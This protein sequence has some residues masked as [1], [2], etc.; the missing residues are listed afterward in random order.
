[1]HSLHDIIEFFLI[2]FFIALLISTFLLPILTIMLHVKINRINERTE[3]LFKYFLNLQHQQ[4]TSKNP[5]ETSESTPII[6][7]PVH[8]VS[9][10]NTTTMVTQNPQPTPSLPAFNQ[11]LPKTPPVSATQSQEN[12]N[13][14]WR[15]LLMG[16]QTENVNCEYSIATTWLIRAGLI[17]FF[18][19]I[20][21]FLQYT[22]ENEF[23]TPYIR[24]SIIYI[25]ATALLLGGLYGI[26]TRFSRLSITLLYVSFFIFYLTPIFGNVYYHVLPQEISM[27]SII[28]TTIISLICALKFNLF[29]LAILSIGASLFL[30]YYLQPKL[31]ILTIALWNTALCGATLG[32]SYFR[33]WRSVELFSTF[34]ILL[35]FLILFIHWNA[36]GNPTLES[37]LLTLL[38]FISVVMLILRPILRKTDSAFGV[39]EWLNTLIPVLGNIL[40]LISAMTDWETEAYANCYLTLNNLALAGIAFLIYLFITKRLPQ[41]IH[42][43]SAY[44]S[45]AIITTAIIFPYTM[46]NYICG[47]GV[48]CCALFSLLLTVTTTKVYRN[49]FFIL[50]VICF[51]FTI[52]YSGYMT[53][54]INFEITDIFD[55]VS[56]FLVYGLPTAALLGSAYL[57]ASCKKCDKP[58]HTFCVISYY[59]IGGAILLF[60]TGNEIYLLLKHFTNGPIADIGTWCWIVSYMVGIIFIGLYRD[61]KSVRITGLIFFIISF[62]FLIGIIMDAF[63]NSLIKVFI[64]LLT[65]IILIGGASAYTYFKKRFIEE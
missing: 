65:G 50:S 25:L 38:F 4:M 8:N 64:L 42:N 23:L 47:I 53:D 39:P 17:I 35:S 43:T 57:L 27:I 48:A 13:S 46:E 1:M 31:S 52:G 6:T 5:N 34:S 26:K 16:R 51:I 2:L 22:L 40:I 54:Y 61:I 60:Y 30:P 33:R 21:T 20:I 10:L 59:A 56:R 63:T 45:A 3:L 18:I 14:F 29:P 24:I 37:N 11:P 28:A 32:I 58:Y 41:F 19:A 62:L 44:L 7:P 15:W 9:P 49:A 55:Y 36:S 12:K